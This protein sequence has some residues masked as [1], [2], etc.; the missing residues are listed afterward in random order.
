MFDLALRPLKDIVT[1]PLV[2]LVPF[3]I[4]PLHLTAVGFLFG[5]LACALASSPVTIDIA[6]FPWLINRIFDCLDGAVA[7]SRNTA[8]QTGGFYDLLCDFITYSCIPIA[9]A[10]GQ[11]SS[12]TGAEDQILSWLS[13]AFLEATF[14][15]NNFVLFYCAAV[16]EKAP[17]ELTSVAMKPA[18]VEGF[19]AGVLFTAMLVFPNQIASISWIMGFLV[20]IGTVQRCLAIDSLL[21]KVDKTS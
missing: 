6:V 18:L 12:K 1:A 5:L 7:R 15:I 3:Y 4:H 9:V 16:I 2:H 8:S 20:V 11:A 10:Y 19:E 13:I 14:H 17:T 21:R